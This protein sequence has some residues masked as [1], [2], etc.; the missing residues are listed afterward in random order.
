MIEKIKILPHGHHFLCILTGLCCI[1]RLGVFAERGKFSQRFCTLST[2]TF[3]G[4]QEIWHK[5]SVGTR[6]LLIALS[7][8]GARR[9]RSW[10]QETCC[11][12]LSVQS[13]GN[14][15]A[16]PIYLRPLRGHENTPSSSWSMLPKNVGLK[17]GKYWWNET[18][19]IT[20]NILL[21]QKWV[22]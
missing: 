6:Q 9:T 18:Y 5:N 16:W 7:S 17:S 22:F 4:D 10:C 20:E 12:L 19:W 1:W 21:F 13:G 15:R 14:W 2:P 8:V 11:H 3:R